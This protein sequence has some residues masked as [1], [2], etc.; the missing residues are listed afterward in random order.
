VNDESVVI[1]RDLFDLLVDEYRSCSGHYKG[2]RLA[3]FTRHDR[4]MEDGA[5]LTCRVLALLDAEVGAS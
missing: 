3:R 2:G 1:P 5:C 4:R